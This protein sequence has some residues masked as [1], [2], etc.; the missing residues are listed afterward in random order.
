MNKLRMWFSHHGPESA[1]SASLHKLSE[2]HILGSNH[3]SR[4]ARA[5]AG[6]SVLTSSLGNS[7]LAPWAFLIAQLVKNPPAMQETLVWFPGLG[8][9]TGK[10]IVYPLQCSWA[11]L[12]AQL[13]KNP[14]AMRE[15]WV[16]SLGQEDP[17]EEGKATHSSILSWKIP[18]QKSIVHEVSKSRTLCGKF[19]CT[20]VLENHCPRHVASDIKSPSEILGVPRVWIS[21]PKRQDKWPQARQN[22][23]KEA[24]CCLGKAQRTWP[25]QSYEDYAVNV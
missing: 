2:M 19:W 12:V 11:S 7:L 20:C 13:V 10:V 9:S 4:N 23:P 3:W 25:E 14:P 1:A 16:R 8:S 6:Q 24:H 5:G 17:L 22:K 18:R 21:D 15:T